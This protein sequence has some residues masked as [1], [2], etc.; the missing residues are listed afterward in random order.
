MNGNVIRLSDRNIS[1]PQYFLTE[2]HKGTIF[3]YS[4]RWLQQTITTGKFDAKLGQ[5]LCWFFSGVAMVGGLIKLTTLTLTEPEFFAGMLLVVAV[6]MLGL[7]AGMILP[8]AQ[9]FGEK[10]DD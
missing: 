7:I 8:I 1:S 3:M 5:V 6:S 4:I 9:H 2:L 10:K